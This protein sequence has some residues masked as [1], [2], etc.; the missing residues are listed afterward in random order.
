[1][2]KLEITILNEVSKIKINIIWYHLYVESKTQKKI[3]MNLY[4]IE[5]ETHRHVKQ[6]YGYQRGNGMG[7]WIN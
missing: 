4:L 5:K 6:T 2:I 1:M 7:G 3:Q